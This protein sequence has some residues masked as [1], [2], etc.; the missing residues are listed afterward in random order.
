MPEPASFFQELNLWRRLWIEVMDKP[1]SIEAT[2]L[3][4]KTCHLMYPNITKIRYLLLLTSVTSSSVERANSSLKY[5][6]NPLRSTMGEDRFNALLFNVHKDIQ[7]DINKIVDKFAGKHSRKMM[8]I[9]PL[10]DK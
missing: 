6:K 4:D 9:N 7:I 5:I 1:D 2:L 10:S 8:L 3:D